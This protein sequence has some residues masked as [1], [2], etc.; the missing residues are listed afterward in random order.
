[1][2][3]LVVDFI[4]LSELLLGKCQPCSGWGKNCKQ[5]SQRVAGLF[6]YLR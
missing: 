2:Y 4:A 1:M 5:K 3:R 6:N